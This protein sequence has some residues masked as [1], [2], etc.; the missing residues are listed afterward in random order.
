MTSSVRLMVGRV[1]Q[2]SAI[3]VLVVAAGCAPKTIA[4][5]PPTAVP[6]FPDFIYPAPPKGMGT[7]A[8]LDRH[9]MAWRWLQAGDP[10]NAERIFST[11][12]KQKTDFYPAEAGLGYAALARKDF[13]SA[14]SHFDRAVQ[15]KP[16][17]AAARAN[18]LES[19][20]HTWR[21]HHAAI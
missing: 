14:A 20:T 13:R 6:K 15:L 8:D 11:L 17:F 5:P 4:V 1:A 7:V 2:A 18:F 9:E 12:L 19:P 3:V 10:R 16:D 21:R